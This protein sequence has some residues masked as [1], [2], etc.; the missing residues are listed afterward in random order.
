MQLVPLP[1]DVVAE[2]FLK[3]ELDL[4]TLLVLPRILHQQLLED[5]LM[6]AIPDIFTVDPVILQKIIV[7]FL[8]VGHLSV[9]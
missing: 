9:L 5:V 4:T 7:G 1:I 8:A 3:R 2:F 6:A